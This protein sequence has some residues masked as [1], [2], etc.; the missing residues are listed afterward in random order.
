[1]LQIIESMFARPSRIAALAL[2]AILIGGEGGLLASGYRSQGI[3]IPWAV[4]MLAGFGLMAGEVHYTRDFSLFCFGVAAL[5][6]GLITALLGFHIWTQLVGFGAISTALLVSV[7]NWLRKKMRSE[8]S[9]TELENIIGQLAFPLDDLPAFGF[10]KA[11]LRG[12]AWG[13]HNATNIAIRRG[14]RCKVMKMNGLT[15]WIIPE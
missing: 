4:W 7:R 9:D 3:E 15:L 6:V 1:M 12:T 10:G 5:L 14:Q 8:P 13:A 2:L 11:E